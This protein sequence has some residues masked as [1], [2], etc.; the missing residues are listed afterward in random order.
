[1]HLF[2]LYGNK[3]SKYNLRTFLIF[4]MGLTADRSG[5][6]MYAYVLAIV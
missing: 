4:L 3:Y 6:K 2:H 1:L 5:Y